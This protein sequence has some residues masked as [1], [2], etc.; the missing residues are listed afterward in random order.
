M[1]RPAK[2]QRVEKFRRNKPACSASAMAAILQDVAKNGLPPLVHRAAFQ[3]ARDEVMTN[4]TPFGPILQHMVCI[5]KSD[6][7]V[8]VP[9]ADPFATLWTFVK[10]GGPTEGNAG[11]RRFF[12]QRLLESP[13]SPEHPWHIILY[14]DEITPGNVVAPINTRKFHGIYWSF[15]E[16]GS[17]ALS[18]E[19]A[20]FIVVIEFSTFVNELHAGISQVFKQVIH[21]FFQQ[22]GFNLM[23]SG[24]L[25]EFEDCNIR[26]WAEIGGILQDGGAHKYVW[27]VRGDGASK[28]CLLCKNLFTEASRVV[29]SDGT[30]LLRCNVI[31]LHDCIPMRGRDLRV[32]ARF[33]AG[34]KPHLTNPKFTELQQ[35][36]G[37]TYHPHAL[38]LD[39]TLDAVLDPCKV[40]MHDSMHGLY[41][42][43]VVNLVMYLLFEAFITA[44]M[45]NVYE[46]FNGYIGRWKWPSRIHGS[47]MSK[48]FSA[49]RAEK[50]RNA[51][52]VKGQASDI[53]SAVQV[54][55]H[56]TR[57]VLY[58]TGNDACK[59]ACEAFI[60]LAIVCELIGE[61]S[62]SAIPAALLLGKIHRFLELFV[63]S[64]GFEWLT[65]KSHW[66]LHLA[67]TLQKLG[68][69]VNC[70]CLERKH[71]VP[72][73]YAEDITNISP[74][75]ST[76]I[77][78]E[79]VC[80]QLSKAQ[81]PGAFDFHVGLIGGRAAP[82]RTRELILRTAGIDDRDDEIFVARESRIN[83]FESCKNGDVVILREGATLRA[84]KI[85]Q[86]FELGGTALS[87]VYPWTLERRVANT[88]F[89]VWNTGGGEG[90][91]WATQEIVAAVEYLP[92]PDGKVGVLLPYSCR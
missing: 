15:L 87:L 43:G 66:L 91:I 71:R 50:H 90:E 73:R 29:E 38:L 64:W 78:K 4:M 48:L 52:H 17:N 5:N 30:N 74:S 11:F 22:N 46:S 3:E 23:T 6:N 61:T 10:E 67:E 45:R 35:A 70:F 47:N 19:E 83:G 25:L 13:P 89:A 86:H 82:R 21:L 44:G 32:N 49:A 8:R 37:L 60:A 77:L 42:D 24:I 1:D 26:L 9:V 7:E 59:K 75:S 16:L 53:M 51:M 27:H 92:Y 69:L 76:S 55:L 14:T 31:K 57:T 54:L 65:P 39:D 68:K 79:A 28:Y 2:L 81:Q 41:V 12:K 84:G 33:L 40:Y 88:S 20:W 36:L 56:F 62:R 63:D 80:H 72:K 58:E 34:Q 85:A 18:R